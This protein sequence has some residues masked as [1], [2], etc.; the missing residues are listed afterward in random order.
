MTSRIESLT[1]Y[2]PFAP[3]F[4]LV[5]SRSTQRILR[6][7]A[8]ERFLFTVVPTATRATKEPM[9]EQIHRNMKVKGGKFLNAE[10]EL[11]DG[12]IFNLNIH[13]DF[14]IHPEEKISEI[15]KSVEGIKLSSDLIAEN[16]NETLIR[17]KITIIGFSV[18]DLSNLISG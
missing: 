13:G 6:Q 16:I 5:M 12:L 7:A 17:E 15:E 4:S 11:H 18:D 9:Q 3:I 14:F 1:G 10:F 2:A 8:I